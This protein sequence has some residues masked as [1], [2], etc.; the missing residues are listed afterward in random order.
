MERA[1]VIRTV[2]GESFGKNYRNRSEG[3][4]KNSSQEGKK[5]KGGRMTQREGGDTG[6]RTKESVERVEKSVTSV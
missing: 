6:M 2:Q 4:R 1:K 3:D 5:K